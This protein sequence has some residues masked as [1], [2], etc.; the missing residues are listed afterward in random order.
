MKPVYRITQGERDI[1]AT[2][3]PFFQSLTMTDN[4]GLEADTLD[5]ELSEQDNQGQALQ[6]PP[7]GRILAVWIGY[8]GDP[9]HYKGQYV[10]DELSYQVN[11]RV[12][13]IHAKSID[14]AS[15]GKVLRS[16]SYVNTS[17]GDVLTRMAARNGWSVAV[18]AE[19]QTI[20]LPYLAQIDESDLHLLS[21][22][23]G[24]YGATAQV[25]NA[26]LLFVRAGGLVSASG[27]PMPVF[28]IRLS[29]LGDGCSY[30]EMGRGYYTG[31]KARYSGEDGSGEV[32]VGQTE[33]LHILREVFDSQ[34]QAQEAVN[35]ELRRIQGQDNTLSLSLD[36]G[37][38]AIVAESVIRLGVDWPQPIREQDWVA[39]SITHTLG[40]GLSTKIECVRSAALVE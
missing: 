32:V 40:D 25:K 5:L 38:P 2:I 18:S 10:V 22:L 11:D 34:E 13:G 16:E 17:L 36:V 7:R 27:L 3:Q 20:A 35:A 9:L 1:T 14:V 21:R 4:V 30:Q 12:L 29:D 26:T 24:I 39:K 31:A 33:V 6:W 28:E 15:T 37:M 8:E 23:G 19:Y